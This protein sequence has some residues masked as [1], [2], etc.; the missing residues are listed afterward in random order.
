M[1]KSVMIRVSDR[2][3]RLLKKKH[4]WFNENVAKSYFKREITFV[5]FTD[6]LANELEDAFDLFF[7]SKLLLFPMKKGRRSKRVAFEFDTI[8]I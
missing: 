4:D 6:L 1:K 7:G 3:A 2:F 8:P 5:D